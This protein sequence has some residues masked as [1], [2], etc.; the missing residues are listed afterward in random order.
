MYLTFSINALFCATLDGVL[1]VAVSAVVLE[2]F[3]QQRHRLVFGVYQYSQVL[4]KRDAVLADEGS[5]LHHGKR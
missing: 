4:G 1:R 3:A 2:V 5:C